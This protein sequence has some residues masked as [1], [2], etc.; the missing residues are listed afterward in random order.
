MV[1]D[2]EFG[3]FGIQLKLRGTH[4]VWLSQGH[5]GWNLFAITGGTLW[6]C[7]PSLERQDTHFL[8]LL[9]EA[10]VSLEYFAAVAVFMAWQVRRNISVLTTLTLSFISSSTE[11]P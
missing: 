11:F 3:R 1:R 9:L 10:G 4:G 7:C 5:S 8:V 6:L 2:S